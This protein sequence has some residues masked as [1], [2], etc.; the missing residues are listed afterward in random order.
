[1][2]RGAEIHFLLGH[3]IRR[4]TRVAE[5]AALMKLTERAEASGVHGNIDFA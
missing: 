3:N 5:C 4:R 1:V 2:Q